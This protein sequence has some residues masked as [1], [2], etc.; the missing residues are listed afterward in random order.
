MLILL[1]KILLK[2]KATANPRVNLEA[3]ANPRG[4]GRGRVRTGA[5]QTLH[6][7]TL[8]AQPYRLGMN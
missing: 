5:D 7:L 2:V 1:P 8:H 6:Q 4:R 3:A